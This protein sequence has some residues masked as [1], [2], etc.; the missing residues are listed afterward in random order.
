[1]RGHVAPAAQTA[2][3]SAEDDDLGVD[4]PDGWRLARCLRCDMWVRSA[5]PDRAVARWDQLPGLDELPKPRRGKPLHDAIL[6]RVV[7]IDR[8]V[9][10]VAFTLIAVAV[11]LL[12]AKLSAVHGF[13]TTLIRNLNDSAGVTSRGPG[14]SW[15]DRELPRLARLESG[16]L[17]DVFAVAV[18]YA[19]VEGTEA[20]GLW[21]E[22]RWAEYLTVIATAGFLPLEIHEL[23]KRVSVLRVLALVVNLAVLVWLVWSKRL[24]GLRGGASAL[25]EDTDWE[26]VLRGYD[27]AAV[28]PDPSR[29]S[30]SVRSDQVSAASPEVSA[31]DSKRQSV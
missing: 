16:A 11:G 24:F 9:H 21:R 28:N 12:M 26:A 18:A 25:H 22:R 2:R 23:A 1:M 14:G 29:R 19:V 20:Y 5:V 27:T 10:A 15:L 31:V 6:L 3:L 30:R 17:R 13:A 7:A 8:A 4:V